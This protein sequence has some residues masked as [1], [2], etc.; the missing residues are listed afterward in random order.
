MAMVECS[1]CGHSF[2]ISLDRCPH[3][4]RPGLF[5]NV[6]MAESGEERE[7]LRNRYDAAVQRGASRGCEDKIAQF[8]NAITESSRAV[9]ARPFD[10]VYRLASSDKQLYATYYQLLDAGIKLP[11]GEKWDVLRRVT[12]AAL[13]PGYEGQIRFATL[14]LND[15]GLA[16][17]GE[18]F[19]VANESMVSH[20]SSVFEENSVIFM[21]RHG[22]KMSEANNLPKGFRSSWDERAKL[23]VA[24]LEDE[25]SLGT[26]PEDFSGKLLR[27]G[28]TSED[29]EF[30]EV[31]IYGPMTART[32]ERVVVPGKSKSKAKLR[33]LEKKLDEAGVH[34]ELC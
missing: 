21:D 6:R 2:L 9:I 33:A 22:V 17:Y 3:C 25:I 15:R 28:K 18:C 5:P 30:V 26:N 19:M 20:R 12:D 11:S 13:F 7:A 34:L 16:N 14:S 8:E 1:Y 27:Q 29:D 31:H 4:A 10:E 24:K 32:L 23:C